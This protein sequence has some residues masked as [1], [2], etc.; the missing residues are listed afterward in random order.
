MA[1]PF[2]GMDPY[3]ESPSLWP[4][5]HHELAAALRHVLTPLLPPRYFVKLVHRRVTDVLPPEALGVVVPDASVVERTTRTGPTPALA[6]AAT[7]ARPVEVQLEVPV[8]GRQPYLQ[9]V[10]TR[11]ERVPVTGA[12]ETER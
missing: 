6:S 7:I 1:G 2:P 8:P 11:R 5:F 10:D 4:D 9:V 12:A 3:L